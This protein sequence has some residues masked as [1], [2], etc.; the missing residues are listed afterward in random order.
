MDS[1]A[2]LTLLERAYNAL[3]NADSLRLAL[4]ALPSDM[5]DM[6]FPHGHARARL[7]SI[8]PQLETNSTAR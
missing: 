1:H 2:A 8:V 7:C 4:E 6:Q 5:I 3:N